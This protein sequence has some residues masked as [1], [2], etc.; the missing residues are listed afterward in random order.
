MQ[1]WGLLY[2]INKTNSLPPKKNKAVYKRNH[3]KFSFYRWTDDM[4]HEK[5]GEDRK[6]ENCFLN[7]KV[8][9]VNH[10][11]T[12]CIQKILGGLFISMFTCVRMHVCICVWCN[13][14]VGVCI[15]SPN[16][17]SNPWSSQ[18]PD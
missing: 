5:R 18:D 2:S 8:L 16:L 9:F 11:S 14:T 15:D 3:C 17:F 4:I 10:K 7:V 6:G 12:S 1:L 13:Y